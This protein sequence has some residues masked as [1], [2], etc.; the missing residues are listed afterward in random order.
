MQDF[1]MMETPVVPVLLA[2]PLVKQSIVTP[3]LTKYSTVLR[4]EIINIYIYIYIY[5]NG[6][7]YMHT[8]NIY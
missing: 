7:Y 5:S 4:M 3:N 1:I 8:Q 6:I 2:P